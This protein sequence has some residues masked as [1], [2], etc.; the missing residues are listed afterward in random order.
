MAKKKR[1]KSRGSVVPKEEPVASGI[2]QH[3][4]DGYVQGAEFL[5]DHKKP[6]TYHDVWTNLLVNAEEKKVVCKR[7]L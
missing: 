7:C 4:A 6:K 3:L 1:S 5:L 2:D